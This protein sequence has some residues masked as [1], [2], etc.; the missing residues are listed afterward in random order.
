MQDST[1]GIKTTK[2]YWMAGTAFSFWNYY[3][4]R[5][6]EGWKDFST[7]SSLIPK[8]RAA[9]VGAPGTRERLSSGEHKGL[10]FISQPKGGWEKNQPNKKTRRRNSLVVLFLMESVK[11]LLGEKISFWEPGCMR[12]WRVK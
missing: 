5:G 6:R 11:K 9:V 2:P 7:N 4:G 1:T 8:L 12:S 10:H 3:R